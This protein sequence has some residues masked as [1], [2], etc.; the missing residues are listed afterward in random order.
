MYLLGYDSGTSSIKATLLDAQTGAV[1]ATA[2]SPETEM[3]VT[4]GRAGW[5]EQPPELWWEHLIKATGQIRAQSGVDLRDVRAIGIA[6][7]MH[8]L[9]LIDKDQQVLRPAILWCDNR[10]VPIGER[11]A[12]ELGSE[13]CL[14]T[15]LNLPGNF[16]FTRLAWVKQNEP[17]IYRRAAKVLLPGDYLALLLTGRAVTTAS[18]ISEWIGWDFPR[19]RPAQLLLDYFDVSPELIPPLVETFAVQGEL[20]KEAAGLLGCKPGT[21]VTY[22]AGDQ[23]NNALSLNVLEP[24]EIAAT[25]GTSGVIYGIAD[26]IQYD[27]ASRVN[28]FL[29]V[30][31]TTQT[32]R[33]GTLMCVNGT[34]RL[35]SWLKHNIVPAGQDYPQMNQLAA[36]V[37]IGAEGL[38]ILPYG[39][40]SERTLGNRDLGASIHHLQ[41]NIHQKEHLLR[42][43]QE[44]IVFGL[45]YGLQIMRDMQIEVNTVR[46]GDANMFLSPLFGQAFAAVT[47]ARVELYNTDGAQGAARGA[48]LGAGVYAKPA[49]AFVGLATT[50]VIEPQGDLAESYRQAYARWEDVLRRE[51]AGGA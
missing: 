33:Y 43:A 6:Y 11:A 45:N 47:G 49:E 26:T 22:R 32:P 44:G 28:T 38:V 9:V 12:A 13:T 25:A 50:R 2:T 23:P 48:G 39:N 18:G 37:P 24:G 15:L 8:G 3:E 29:H 41:L 7:Q 4:A 30:N 36:Q 19:G 16:T 14:Q 27:P 5:A 42:A 1:A 20:S 31:H 51:L 17:E 40:S 10:A 35:N 34:G 46:A 21:P